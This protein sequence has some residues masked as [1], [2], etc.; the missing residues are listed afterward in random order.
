MSADWDSTALTP[1]QR[2]LMLVY[3]GQYQVS[4]HD[5]EVISARVYDA[6]AGI[7]DVYWSCLLGWHCTCTTPPTE[8]CHHQLAVQ[9]V[10]HHRE[11]LA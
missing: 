3:R 5:A 11:A 10:T 7:F 2:A 6:P 4:R 9:R 1:A 8:E